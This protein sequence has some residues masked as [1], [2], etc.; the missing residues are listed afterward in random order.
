MFKRIKFRIPSWE[1][2]KLIIREDTF[3]LLNLLGGTGIHMARHHF[4][5][6]KISIIN[7]KILIQVH[8]GNTIKPV[9]E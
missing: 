8:K 2:I 4:Y 9:Q 3:D 6:V 1:Q 7:I 5:T